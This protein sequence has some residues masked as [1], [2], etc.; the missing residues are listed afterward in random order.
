MTNIK[1]K[2]FVL[3]C[4]EFQDTPVD[5]EYWTVNV[6]K[7]KQK[8]LKH[9]YNNLPEKKKLKIKKKDENVDTIQ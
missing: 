9:N 5:N 4:F 7:T 6:F 8:T 2:H 3:P 1:Q